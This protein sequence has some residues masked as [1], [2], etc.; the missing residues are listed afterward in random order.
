MLVLFFVLWTTFQS[1]QAFP[2][3]IQH[4]VSKTENDSLKAVLFYDL[5]K[6]Y[7]G[8]DQDT[9]I[10][11]AKSAIRLAEKLGL[12]KIKGNALNIMGV[13][14]LIRSDY[15]DALKTH[16]QA[17]K[18][19]EALK[20]STGMLE[21]NLNI[22]NVYYRNGEMAKA[23]EMY[24]KALVY[25]LA[26]K[27]LRGQSLIYNNLGNY[28]KDRWTQNQDQKD[29]DL[30]LNYLQKSLQ[31]KEELKDSHGLVNT[32]TQLAELN[33]SDRGK[34]SGYLLRALDI[35]EANQDVENKINVLNEL[36]N[37]FLQ[38]KD[39]AK[40]KEYALKSYQ[41]A[42]DA[43][44]HFYISTTAEYLVA[45]ALGQND[46]KAAYEYLVVKKA[47]DE[48]LFND[49]RQKVREELLI[50]YETERKE[51]ENQQLIQ[52]QEYLDL[53]LR[54]RN[55]L[56]IGSGLLLIAFGTLFWFQKKNHLKLKNAHVQLENAHVLAKEQNRR[57][58]SQADHWN[59]TNQALTKANQFR[60]K[61]FSVISHDLR[62]P[63]SSLHSII[64]LWDKKL[65]SQ[66][67]LQE[68]MPLIAR[69]T[70][71]LSQM[72]NN[73]LIWSREQMG[74][75]EVQ[76][77]TFK[78]GELV[79]ENVE[80]LISQINLKNLDFTHENQTELEVH[81]DR[82]RLS[83]IVR[84]ILMNAIKFSPERGKIRVDYP[85]GSEIR[86]TDSGQGIE[87]EILSKLFSD[88]VNSQ[89]GTAGESGTGIGLMLSKEFADSLG[90]EILVE[91]EV[92][93][94][95][96]FRVVLKQKT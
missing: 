81:S 41:L 49:N 73:L 7:Y 38:G 8:I 14:Q 60:D 77:S 25:G 34:A 24:Q 57:I 48:A 36:S 30:A 91:S 76:L 63:F 42:K 9:A 62:A 65:L 3:S 50:Q 11:F 75:E 78:L 67:E 82:E 79:N 28:H 20:D 17:L 26:I 16:L 22:G 93:V 27:N 59:E 54:R 52:D 94:G 69:D 53:S 44:S 15:E 95:T 12:E 33:M 96:S 68:V 31:I 55:E 70:H 23:A 66:D 72:L 19:R 35:A 80:L 64:Q 51:L 56:L 85:N 88:R 39:Y 4:L 58:Q 32:L 83:F 71:S 61:I 37:Y 43:N 47:S 40:V 1:P 84:N 18:I 13:A 74:V 21:S 86:I 87:P 6:H 5:G 29:L 92:G 10:F 45:A 2:D 90:A 89:K 46:Y